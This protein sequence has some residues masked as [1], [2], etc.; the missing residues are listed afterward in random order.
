MTHGMKARPFSGALNDLPIIISH[1][2][3]HPATGLSQGPMNPHSSKPQP[4][5]G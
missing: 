2:T 5:Y 4:L 1:L 3:H